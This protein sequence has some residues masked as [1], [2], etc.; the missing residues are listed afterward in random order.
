MLQGEI[1]LYEPPASPTYVTYT[2][3]YTPYSSMSEG[4]K[5]RFREKFADALE[6]AKMFLSVGDI[7]SLS[8]NPKIKLEVLYFLENPED[9]MLYQGELCV[10]RARNI[11]QKGSGVLYSLK[12]L[13]LI[14]QQ[15]VQA[16]G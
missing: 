14:P 15:E 2:S 6:D 7:V 3:S 9:T 1:K 11:E 10:V 12:E 13:S 4:E 8:V 5:E 16:N